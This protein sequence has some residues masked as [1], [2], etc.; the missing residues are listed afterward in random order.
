MYLGLQAVIAKSF[1]RI[2]RA[3]LINF[4]VL[5]LLFRDEADYE[6]MEQGD[7][8]SIRGLPGALRDGLT[9]SVENLTK[10]YSFEVLCTLNDREKELILKGGLLPHTKGGH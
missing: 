7:R 8:L 2:H 1:A 3:N 4:G 9:L 6:R 5:P 10:G